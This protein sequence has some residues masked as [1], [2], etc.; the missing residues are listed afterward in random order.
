[1]ASTLS[2]QPEL[3]ITPETQVT[4]GPQVRE[5]SM[6]AGQKVDTSLLGTVWREA[7]EIQKLGN[8]VLKRKFHFSLGSRE[9]LIY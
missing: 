2:P 9:R 5:G 3:P 6:P 4:M 1:M 8:S 7:D